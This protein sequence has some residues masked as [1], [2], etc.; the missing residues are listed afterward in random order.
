MECSGHGKCTPDPGTLQRAITNAK[1]AVKFFIGERKI[2][3]IQLSSG[4]AGEDAPEQAPAEG[5]AGK[6]APKE[7]SEE[8]PKTDS[9][10]DSNEAANKVA[11]KGGKGQPTMMVCECDEGYGGKD[12]STDVLNRAQ[13]CSGM[14]MSCHSVHVPPPKAEVPCLGSDYDFSPDSPCYSPLVR[15][16]PAPPNDPPA[17]PEAGEGG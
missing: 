4:K 7:D 12:C 3:L 10:E 2:A 17:F 14:D 13:D 1:S 6:D 11:L 9:E 8:D 15:A 5:K 16:Y